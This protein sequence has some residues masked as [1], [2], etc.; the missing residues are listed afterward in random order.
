MKKTFSKSLFKTLFTSALALSSVAAPVLASAQ[1]YDALINEA[2]VQIEGLS[3]QQTALYAQLATAYAEI[4]TI[5]AEATAVLEAVA[6]DDALIAELEE[7]ITQ[8]EDII[9]KREGLLA[10]QARAVQV[11]G[12][13]SNYLNYVASSE[14]V[15]D[16][17]GRV[18]VINKMV[19]ANKDLLNVQISDKEDV[20]SK[21]S[22]TESTKNQKIEKMVELE[23]LKEELSAQTAA[24]EEVYNQLT[25][26]ISLAASHR[27]ALVA[28]RQA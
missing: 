24:S 15:S 23:A 14:S 2:D 5:Q 27:E 19:S 26:D 8:L 10:D 9:G 1:N 4:D 22:E 11:S 12:G 21:K 3:A 28:E 6:E 16:F 18:D 7:E 25:N 17:V 13:S 20:E